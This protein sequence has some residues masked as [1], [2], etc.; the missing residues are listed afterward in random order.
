[1]GDIFEILS[2]KV[3]ERLGRRNLVI[4]YRKDNDGYM[5]FYSCCNEDM[6]I[7]SSGKE[8]HFSDGELVEIFRD[9]KL[10]YLFDEG[11]QK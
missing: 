1:M 6:S 11:L 4:S 8:I 3:F 7:I 5:V 9:I 2:R 10:K